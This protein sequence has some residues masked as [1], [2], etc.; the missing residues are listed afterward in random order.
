R[1][2]RGFAIAGGTTQIQR[3]LIARK[4]LGRVNRR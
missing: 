1:D 3:N 2:A 4:A